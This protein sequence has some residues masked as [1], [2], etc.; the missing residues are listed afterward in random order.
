M[1]MDAG[2]DTGAVLMR[3]SIAIRPDDT[4]GSLH[5]RLAELGASA[6]LDCIQQ[7]VAGQAL[8]ALAQEKAGAS[9]AAKLEKAEAELDWNEEAATL[10]RRIRAFNPWPMAWCDISGER[11]RITAAMAVPEIHKQ[12]PGVVLRTGPGGIDV[13]TTNGVLRILRLQ[14]PGGAEVSAAEYLHAVGVPVRLSRRE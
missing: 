3:R 11:T 1:Q 2:L 7:L 14:R 12:L 9:Y 13:A 8:S 5:D 10:A 6:L 4:A